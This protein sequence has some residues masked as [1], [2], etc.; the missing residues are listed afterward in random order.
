MSK[1][2]IPLL[3]AATHLVSGCGILWWLEPEPPPEQAA[4][5]KVRELPD[6]LNGLLAV[7]DRSH[8]AN[9][10]KGVHLALA[11]LDKARGVAPEDPEVVWREA[12]SLFWLAQYGADERRLQWGRDAVD[13]ASKMI[14]MQPDRVEGHYYKAGALG[15][16]LQHD[17]SVGLKRISE[18]IDSL[19]QAI[20]IDGRFS[21]AAP[22]LALGA[23]LLKAPPF[24]TGPG[25]LDAA[26]ESLEQAVK[27]APRWPENWLWLAEA[28][29]A[30]R[31]LAGAK[32]DA[33]RCLVL[34]EG[35]SG[36]EAGTWRQKAKKIL[37][38]IREKRHRNRDAT[39][40]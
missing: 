32:R 30:D 14:G 31:D 40:F 16:V 4:A 20:E 3:L 26:L 1:L 39:T 9:T 33:K 18:V 10:R 37:R 27:H 22:H 21:H 36:M 25:D 35:M 15:L 12:R 23:I 2:T 29:L 7:A 24:P 6:D 8:E 38:Q 19:H 17:P 5:K 13:R 34:L 28:K 11:A